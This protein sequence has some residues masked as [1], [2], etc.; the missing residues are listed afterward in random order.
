MLDFI[1]LNHTLSDEL[2]DTI[3]SMF[4]NDSE[5]KYK[6]RVTAGLVEEL[7]KTTDLNITNLPEWQ[8]IVDEL[9]TTLQNHLS[10]Y[11]NKLTKNFNFNPLYAVTDT[12]SQDTFQ[13]QKYEKNNGFYHEHMDFVANDKGFRVLTF[14]WYLNDVKEGG[15]TE[16]I[17]S[18]SIK[19][20][21]GYLLLFPA[22]WTFPHKGKMPISSDKYIIT[23]WLYS[24]TPS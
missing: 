18:F 22:C 17:G 12:F 20:K 19:P 2:C 1:Y 5:N 9:K 6:G 21:K 15:E 14:L 16:F 4:E 8:N 11:S 3:I 10:K 7:K 24:G 13:I 23:G